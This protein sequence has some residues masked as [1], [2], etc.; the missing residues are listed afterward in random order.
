[1]TPA[2]VVDGLSEYNPRLDI[3]AYP[4]LAAWLKQYCET[5]RAGATIVYRRCSE[6]D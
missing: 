5:G 4:E 3:H 1:M 2:F 6:R